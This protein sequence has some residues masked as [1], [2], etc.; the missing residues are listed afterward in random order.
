MWKQMCWTRVVWPLEMIFL[1]GKHLGSILE[2]WWSLGNYSLGRIICKTTE[3]GLKCNGTR[4]LHIVTRMSL[5][6]VGTLL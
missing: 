5:K 3:K 6:M 1:F 4:N 2:D